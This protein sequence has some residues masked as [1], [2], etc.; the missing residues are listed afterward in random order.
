M[1]FIWENAW[2]GAEPASGSVHG[3]GLKTP[4]DGDILQRANWFTEC[5]RH[6]FDKAGPVALGR[7]MKRSL[8]NWFRDRAGCAATS[9]ETSPAPCVAY[10]GCGV[11]TPVPYCEHPGDHIWPDF[12]SAAMWDFFN[13][14]VEN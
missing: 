1:V 10:E 12:G 5:Y 6:R 2:Q 11:D 9:V 3:V 7:R 13:Q 8:G 4:V 14:F